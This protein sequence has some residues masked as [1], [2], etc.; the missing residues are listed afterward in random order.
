[1]TTPCIRK[2]E[3]KVFLKLSNMS[4][5][6]TIVDDNLTLHRHLKRMYR[7]LATVLNQI[8][9]HSRF[10]SAFYPQRLDKRDLPH[11]SGVVSAHVYQYMPM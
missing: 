9:W 8:T 4:N 7:K 1:M 6:V 3:M 2:L 11:S 10:N 5:D